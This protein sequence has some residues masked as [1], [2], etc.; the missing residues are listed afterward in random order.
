[1]APTDIQVK[2]TY[3][4]MKGYIK[5]TQ[6]AKPYYSPLGFNNPRLPWNLLEH[7]N[8]SYMSTTGKPPTLL[9]LKQHAQSLS[10]L[11]SLLAPSQVGAEIDNENG[12]VQGDTTFAKH[13]AWDWLNNLSQ[14]YTSEDAAHK[15]PLNALVN[16][17]E[18]QRDDV[19]TVWHCP[20][21]MTDPENA[22]KNRQPLRPFE[23]HMTLLMHANDCLERL[24]HEYSA[25]GGLMSIIP[26]DAST[27]NEKESLT[28]AKTTLVGQWILFTQHL[29]ARMHELEI[30]YANSIDL[31]QNEAIV[32][33]QH[34]GVHGPDGRSGR[35]IV[36]P[37]DRWILA[38]AGE[39]VTSFVH[40][41][42]DKREAQ[43]DSE[44]MV[45][46]AQE[47][48]G[49]KA[50]DLDGELRYRGIVKVDLNTR[51]YRIRGSGHGPIFVLPAFA[52]R[53]NTEY[54][55][56]LENRPTVMTMPVPSFPDGTSAWD[57][58]HR[59]LEDRY[60]KLNNKM[61]GLRS[62]VSTLENTN[63]VLEAQ[64]QTMRATLSKYE[65]DG[66]RKDL[67]D[68]LKSCQ[69]HGKTLQ[70][71][72]T[73][74]GQQDSTKK[75][76]AD[77]QKKYDASVRRVE[78]LEAQNRQLEAQAKESKKQLEDTALQSVQQLG[79]PLGKAVNRPDETT[80]L[81]CFTR[82]W[83]AVVAGFRGAQ[84]A[85]E[86][87]KKAIPKY[88]TLMQA[89]HLTNDDV[90]WINHLADVVTEPTGPLFNPENFPAVTTD[91]PPPQ[92]T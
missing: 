71:H 7:V 83:D 12:K 59:D 35:E 30:A 72:I 70:D 89:G 2:E 39:D 5:A 20:L 4:G 50:V 61:L 22:D 41:M 63:K 44:D 11:I 78:G 25:T 14:H 49:D 31:L 23:T 3:E 13:Q 53:P 18:Y 33:M 46:Q 40:Q 66:S 57:K 17:I 80:I 58:R 51:F 8:C 60:T 75:A 42:L 29:A 69:D 54:T 65:A 21:T 16:L 87:A 77:L 88:Q 24:D 47:V 52:D 19:G 6:W 27:S 90:L 10:V 56:D 92:A 67:E 74:L 81:Y 84:R 1:M 85:K 55:R 43:Q 15:S 28:Q 32:P 37:Q 64:N 62:E 86:A 79:V 48:M 26:L 76:F 68:K 36:F 38:N 9:A 45:F 73:A 91:V 82:E 34:V